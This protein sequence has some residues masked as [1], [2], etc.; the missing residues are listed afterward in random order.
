MPTMSIAATAIFGLER[1]TRL[2]EGKFF[3]SRGRTSTGWATDPNGDIKPELIRKYAPEYISEADYKAKAE[4]NKARK[5]LLEASKM[6]V[7]AQFEP[8][9]LSFLAGDDENQARFATA[10]TAAQRKQPRRSKS[11]KR[12]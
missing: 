1:I 7:D 6:V 5:A 11:S 8:P 10:I 9:V 2:T 12:F 4:E 3:R